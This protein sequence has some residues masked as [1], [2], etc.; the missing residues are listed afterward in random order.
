MKQKGK[1]ERLSGV[2]GGH[3]V[4]HKKS[5]KFKCA[6]DDDKKTFVT[7]HLNQGLIVTFIRV[8]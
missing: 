8:S 2:C 4:N 7:L 5:E 6:V 1:K 3:R